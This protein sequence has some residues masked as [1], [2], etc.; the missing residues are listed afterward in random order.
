MFSLFGDN[1]INEPVEQFK[2]LYSTE[3]RVNIKMEWLSYKT[4]GLAKVKQFK[5]DYKNVCG[6]D[7]LQCSDE[8]D[9]DTDGCDSDDDEIA[10]RLAPKKPGVMSAARKQ[11]NAWDN[12]YL[13]AIKPHDCDQPIQCSYRTPDQIYEQH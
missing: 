9:D 1:E 3:E 12:Q 13:S 10:N 4:F 8:G 11:G 5:A 6:T 2:P 7:E